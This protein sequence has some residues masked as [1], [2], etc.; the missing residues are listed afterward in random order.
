[1]IQL[2]IAVLIVLISS[3]LCSGAEAA[4]FSVPLV[5]VRQLGETRKPAALALLKIRQKMSRPIATIV[6]LNNVANIVGSIVVGGIATQVLGSQ[7]LGVFSGLLTFLVIIFAEIIPK[8]LGE[9]YA[10]RIGLIVARPVLLLTRIFTPLVWCIE[11]VTAPITKGGRYP[12]TNEAEIRLLAH[13]GSQEGIIDKRESDMIQRVFRLNDLTADDIMTPRV[14][15]TYLHGDETLGEAKS[16]ILASQHS[17][18]IV[19]GNS[20]DNVQGIVFKN[21]LL[22]AMVEAKYDQPIVSFKHEPQFVPEST[23]ADRLLEVFQKTR[24]HLVVVL[25]EFGGTAGVVTLEDVLE[26][27]TGEIVDETDTVID[28]RHVMRRRRQRPDR[29]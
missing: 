13:I 24:R 22:A 25:D 4:L 1:M 3:A 12:V 9:R 15:L 8:T 19:I 16:A 10:E 26:V 6:I 29:N 11:K 28:L 2:L 5:R 23:H 21:E 14:N 7:W 18:I 27:L 20:I 17:R